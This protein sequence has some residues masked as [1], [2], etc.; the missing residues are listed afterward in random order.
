MESVDNLL[1]YI[2]MFKNYTSAKIEKIKIF[3]EKYKIYVMPAVLL[4]GFL[5]DFLTLRRVD[6]VFDN[7]IITSHLF[8]AG[9]AITLLFSKD[10]RLGERLKI[11][12]HAQKIEYV[13]LFSFGALFSGSI[14]FFSKSAS[15][16]SSWPFFL[17]L[18]ILMLGTEFQKKYFQRLI[19]QIN[20]YYIA[21]LSYLI[22]L[23]PV[24]KKDMGADI[25][26]AS[27]ILSLIAIFIFFL[28]LSLIDRKK[29]ILYLKKMVTGVLLVFISFN[30]FYFTNIIPPIPLSL[31]FSGV[32]HS[33]Y[34]VSSDNYVGTY[35][36]NSDWNFWQKRSSAI[37]RDRDGAV[38]VFSSVF[39]PTRLDTKIY[40]QW[41]YFNKVENKW[42]DSSRIELSISGG[43]EDGF[44]GY[45][46]KRNLENGKWRVVVETARGQKLG[47]IKFM[48]DSKEGEINL[49][50]EIL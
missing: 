22:V 9:L 47:Q 23:V 3:S 15:L 46:L 29:I 7:I 11:A 20:F 26:I 49:K 1:Y 39:A 12:R 16:S 19:F 35:E 4:V 42:V 13:M 32:Y 25:F 41:Q 38:Y 10:T 27:G 21:L 18:L 34:R 8:L 48:I 44:R 28:I 40:H 37:H 6:G 14:I 36:V 17:L 24:L 5:L 50:E 45:S 30:L 33:V 43:R 2:N 31:K